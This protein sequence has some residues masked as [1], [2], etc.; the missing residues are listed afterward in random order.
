MSFKN[1]G[2]VKNIDYMDLKQSTATTLRSPVF[3]LTGPSMESPKKQK[4][5]ALF[6]ITEY[7]SMPDKPCNYSIVEFFGIAKAE[8]MDLFR[9]MI[10]NSPIHDM[11]D[12]LLY[13][14]KVSHPQR[15]YSMDFF[16]N[17]EMAV[18]TLAY[19]LNGKI[20]NYAYLVFSISETNVPSFDFVYKDYDDTFK[21]I[22]ARLTPPTQKYM[23]CNPIRSCSDKFLSAKHVAMLYSF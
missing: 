19:N 18:N 11:I 17:G 12:I 14:L 9:A 10:Q 4:T 23:E 21:C 2:P 22:D 8:D 13:W 7:L 6:P 5:P 3:T 1:K 16:Q 20:V 15:N